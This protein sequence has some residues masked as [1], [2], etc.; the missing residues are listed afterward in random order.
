VPIL[1]DSLRRR[2]DEIDPAWKFALS[3]Y[4]LARGFLTVWSLILVVLFPVVLQNLD[5][6]GSPIVAVFD[7]TTGER[8][9]YSRVVEGKTLTFRLDDPRQITDL[10]TGSVWSLREG[11][12]IAGAYAGRALGASLYS[13]EEIF[14]YRGI[15]PETNLF[16]SVW[17]RFDT[18]WYLAIAERGYADDGS[19]VYFP[20]YPLL[21]RLIGGITGNRMFAALLISNLAA[22]GVLY[23]LYRLT[24]HVL[25]VAAAQRAIAYLLIFPTGFFLLA[26]YTESLFLLFTLAAF[27]CARRDRWLLAALF[28]AL[29]ALTRLQGVLLVVP[30]V[31]MGWQQLRHTRRA[32]RFIFLMLIPLAT[33]AFLAYTNLSLIASYEG[34]LHARFVL[35]WDNVLACLTLFQTGKGSFI[36]GLNL[37]ATLGFGAML[38]AV[39][40]KLPCEFAFY[41]LLM[42]CAPLFRM[43]TL[44]PLVSMDRYVLAIFPAFM[45]LGARGQNAWLNRA[46][47]YLSFPLQLYLCAQFI[48]WGWVG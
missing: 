31:W 24:Q 46:M 14:P 16:L 10:E 26:A 23:L 48:L 7:L 8:F 28:G 47:V 30:L 19:T 44:Q 34:E 40:R 3:A 18:N 27:D 15:A 45:W 11:R 39:W 42:F 43:T 29:A 36:D 13:V 33:L 9:A 4:I 2:I 32:S 35:P 22:I 20:L 25:D 21:I 12:A 17:Q 38:I 1:L 41:A 5:L 37:L 6:F